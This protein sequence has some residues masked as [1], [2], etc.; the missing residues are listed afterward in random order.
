MREALTYVLSLPVSTV[1]V[2]CDTVAQRGE[3]V[4]LA[5]ASAP[6]NAAHMA[7]LEARAKPLARQALVFRRWG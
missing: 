1:I 4:A 2:G 3:N 6:Y 5:R 7:A